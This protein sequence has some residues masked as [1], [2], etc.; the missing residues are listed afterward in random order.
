M[1]TE[2]RAATANISAHETT[3]RLQALSTAFLI[4]S[5]TLNPLT[6]FTF[7]RAV[8]SPL[9]LEVSSSRIDPSQPYIQV[10]Q[11]SQTR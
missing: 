7:G 5:I 8:F 6:E 9:K 10:V 2:S 1:F 4:S 3:L 11:L